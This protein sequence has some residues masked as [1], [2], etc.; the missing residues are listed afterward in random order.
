MENDQPKITAFGE[1]TRF[2]R[3]WERVRNEQTTSIY[4][5]ILDDICNI[6][7]RY[8]MARTKQTARLSC[9]QKV[10]RMNLPISLVARRS[11]G[12]GRGGLGAVGPRSRSRDSQSSEP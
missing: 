6:K 2:G 8:K 9:A 5:Q 10:P 7:K 3:M 1:I 12:R 4:K 11:K